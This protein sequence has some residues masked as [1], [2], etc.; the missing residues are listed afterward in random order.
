MYYLC[1]ENKGAYQLRGYREADLRL[2]FRIC[3]TPVFSGRGS[4]QLQIY[5]DIPFLSSVV[6]K[7]SL[8]ILFCSILYALFY[9][10]IMYFVF[11]T[12]DL[13]T[14]NLSEE[15]LSPSQRHYSDFKAYNLSKLCNVLFSMHLNKLLSPYGVTSLSLHPGNMMWTNLASN[16]W[17]Y[18]MLF[19]IA[20]PFTKS[21]V[22]KMS[23]VARKPFFGV[24]EQV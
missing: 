24:Y 7:L 19:F 13:N 1:S 15:K 8:K 20:R 17:F 18:K 4:Y 9:P 11:R 14:S 16:W 3:K 12:T 10:L 23:R 6:L 21:M 22:G 2:C 5:A